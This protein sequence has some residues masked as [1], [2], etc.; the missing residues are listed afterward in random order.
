MISKDGSKVFAQNVDFKEVKI[1]FAAYQKK[2]EYNYPF[3]DAKNYKLNKFLTSPIKDS[4]AELNY[5]D[6]IVTMKLDN[7]I[8]LMYEKNLSLIEKNL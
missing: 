7:I 5:D 3:L 8:S 6:E 4:T 1:P 2:N